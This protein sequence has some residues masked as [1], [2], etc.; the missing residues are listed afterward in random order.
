MSDTLFLI[1]D[2]GNTNIKAALAAPGGSI[3]PACAVPTRPG[4]PALGPALV[5]LC[6]GAGVAPGALGGAVASSVVPWADEAVAALVR[7]VAGLELRFAPRDLPFGFSNMAAIPPN[8]G[9]DRLA[10]AFGA[11]VALPDAP[12]LVVLD[13]GTATTVDCV[14]GGEYLGGLTCPGLRTAADALTEGTALLPPLTLALDE[15]VL[16]LG[17]DTMTS[18]NQGFLFG[19]AALAEG[20][21]ARLTALL[22]VPAPV[23]ATG[24]LA[25]AVAAL[26]PA[27][28]HVRPALVMEGL[29]AALALAGGEASFRTGAP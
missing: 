14:R 17:F 10:G 23:V 1:L 24:G 3:G 18:L 16:R 19:F 2:I 13:F 26:C 8:V 9:A 5:A 7:A 21:A 28:G 20:L 12:G 6:A 4:A 11:R 22:G 27:I 29:C 25:S 15:P